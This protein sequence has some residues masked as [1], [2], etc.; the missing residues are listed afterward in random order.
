MD[1]EPFHYVDFFPLIKN[2]KVHSASH[3]VTLLHFFRERDLWCYV[4]APLEQLVPA[5]TQLAGSFLTPLELVV[6]TWQ[7]SVIRSCETNKFPLNT[8]PWISTIQVYTGICLGLGISM[9]SLIV[10]VVVE[11]NT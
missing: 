8:F 7:R 4:A 2:M 3:C 9:K 1:V 6:G 5:R 10:S 11:I